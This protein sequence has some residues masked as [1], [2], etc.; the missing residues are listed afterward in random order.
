M[1]TNIEKQ[2]VVAQHKRA[3]N[4]TASPEVQVALLSLDISKLTD[5]M[6]QHKA[7]VHS[8]RGLIAKV[9]QRRRLLR[10]L[11]SRDVAAYRTLIEK[12]GIRE[13]A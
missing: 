10:Y 6:N 13:I 5:H 4:D 1:L 7:D 12:L 11:R 2:T 3:A 9:N 8:R